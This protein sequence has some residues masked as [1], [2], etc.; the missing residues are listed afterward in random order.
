MICQ[1]EDAQV[2]E[3]IVD[4]VDVRV[5]V[6]NQRVLLHQLR[7][8]Q[9]HHEEEVKVCQ[10]IPA[11]HWARLGQFRMH[12]DRLVVVTLRE[13]VRRI[14]AGRLTDETK[15]RNVQVLN[16]L[17][18]L[19]SGQFFAI[20]LAKQIECLECSRQIVLHHSEPKW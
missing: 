12:R 4:G 8:D 7:V 18:Q 16:V 10:Q 5:L 2:K 9:C 13:M 17:V 15:T 6:Q 19:V 20:E 11:Q 14:A 3:C 1:D